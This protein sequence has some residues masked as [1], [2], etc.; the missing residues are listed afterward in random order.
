MSNIHI[1]MAIHPM[2]SRLSR[3][4]SHQGREELRFTV[5]TMDYFMKWEE[6]EPL[7]AIKASSVTKF[8]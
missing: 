6:V 7:A 1:P 4:S 5:V 2:G 8:L 3:A